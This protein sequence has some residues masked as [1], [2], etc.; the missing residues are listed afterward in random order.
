[1]DI[2]VVKRKLPELIGA[3]YNP[4]KISDQ[5]LS[6]LKDSIKRFGITE[7]ILVNV[8]PSR[9]DIIISGHQ[10]ARVCQELGIKEV[11]CIE[12]DLTHDKERELNIRMNKANRNEN[13]IPI[14]DIFLFYL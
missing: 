13:S 1:M 8:N 5:Q 6:D 3:E 2:Q 4:R 9:Q 10:R 7:P 11:P 14:D 12:L